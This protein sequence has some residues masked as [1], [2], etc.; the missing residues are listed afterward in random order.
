MDNL[1]FDRAYKKYGFQSQRRYPNEALL[2]F[3]GMEFFSISP[4]DREKIKVLEIGCGSGANMWVVA[5]EGFSAYGI[6]VSPTGLQLCG[7][8]LRNWGASANLSIQP[9]EK[10]NF[11][12]N[13]FNFI[14]D[15]V[16]MQHLDWQGHK[17][18]YAEV[19]RCLKSGGKF[20]QW[21][22][23]AKSISFTHG[24]GNAIDR[25]TIDNISNPEVP[26]YNSGRVCFLKPEDAQNMLGEAGFTGINVETYNR[27]YKHMTQNIEYLAVSARK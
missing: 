10:L 16:S 13:Y 20:F 25:C 14:F 7:Q 21:H 17:D 24:G 4:A 8:M 27:T 3:M 22:L 23:G 9:M 6:D 1:H 26:L 12:S 2:Q 18:A 11:E 19:Y 15:V 5:K